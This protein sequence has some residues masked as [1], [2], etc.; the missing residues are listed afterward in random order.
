MYISKKQYVQMCEMLN[1]STKLI[2]EYQK[3]CNQLE[4]DLKDL[5][6]FCM[7]FAADHDNFNIDFPNSNER[8]FNT[9]NTGS[10]TVSQNL[11]Y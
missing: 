2:M 1:D 8:G 5:Q 3:K 9:A 6:S 4:R 10:D 7:R 11:D